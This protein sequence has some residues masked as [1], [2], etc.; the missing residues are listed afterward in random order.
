MDDVFNQFGFCGRL[1]HNFFKRFLTMDHKFSIGFKSGEFPGHSKIHIF[2]FFKQ[3][4][5]MLAL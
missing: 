5:M 4:V 2:T 1:Q 3:F